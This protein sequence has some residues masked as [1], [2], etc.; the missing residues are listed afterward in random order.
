MRVG[1]SSWRCQRTHS[2]PLQRGLSRENSAKSKHSPE[3]HRETDLFAEAHWSPA[4]IVAH[5]GT[6]FKW[7]GRI[8]SIAPSGVAMRNSAQRSFV[9]PS[10]ERPHLA[11]LSLSADVR[12]LVQPVH[13]T[14][15]E[16]ALRAELT[17]SANALRILQLAHSFRYRDRTGTC[18]SGDAKRKFSGRHA[19]TAVRLLNRKGGLAATSQLHFS[20]RA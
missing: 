17:R 7:L 15:G 13:R 19:A 8:R 11:Q 5:S 3:A 12:N 10:E 1:L 4:E 6:N 9:M 2:P 20:A 16:G 14:N 18:G